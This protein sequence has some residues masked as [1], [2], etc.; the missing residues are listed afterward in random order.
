MRSAFFVLIAGALFWAGQQIYYKPK[1]IYGQDIP[2]FSVE[3]MSGKTLKT[4][5]LE[6]KYVL[7][8]FWGSWCGPCR[9][10]SPEL[11]A[12]YKDFGRSNPDVPF[13]I[14]SIGIETRQHRWEKA[15]DADQLNWPWHYS[16]F[17]RFKDPLAKEFGI[18]EIP[19]K[20]LVDPKG[21]IIGVNPTFEDIRS[22]L[23]AIQP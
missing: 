3:L 8:D 10:E 16:S 12:L 14:F 2:K 9:K 11:V 17:K 19:T 18:K 21:M 4:A 5:D 7:I 23:S 1:Y 22:T 6:G 13:E 15:I 20:F